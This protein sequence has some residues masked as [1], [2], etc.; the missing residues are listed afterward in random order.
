VSAETSGSE[1]DSNGVGPIVEFAGR[2]LAP[3]GALTA[4]LYYFGYV[5]EQALFSY[6]G[7]DLGSVGFSTNDYLI[8]SA[9]TVFLP[10]ATVLVASVAVL[11]A[12]H[13][14]VYFL[15]RAGRRWRRAAWITLGV[16]TLILLIAGMV[17][18]QRRAHPLVSPLASPVALLGGALLLEYTVEIVR[19]NESIPGQLSTVLASTRILR[20]GLMTALVLIAAFWATATVAQERG[21]DAAT[22]IEISLPIQPQAVVYSHDRLEITGPGVSLSRLD[23][24]NSAYGFRYNGLRTLLHAGGHWFLLPA[25]W[26]H[27]NG[28]TVIVLP[29][30]AH[31]IRVDLAP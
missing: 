24:A 20:R 25:G 31:D 14:I 15:A 28:T 16:I 3:A 9:D 5:R 6:F 17:G 29:D 4:F 23:T 12:H 22:A 2:V 7:V 8:R 13:L 19:A 30:S 1:A 27:D 10:L 26:T 11:I 18:L 21:I